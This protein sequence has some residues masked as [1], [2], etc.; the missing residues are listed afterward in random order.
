M[1]KTYYY[2][3]RRSRLHSLRAS[4]EEAVRAAEEAKSHFETGRCSEGNGFSARH[5]N[6]EYGY[7]VLRAIPRL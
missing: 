4:K 2:R 5:L 3:Y 1:R 7:Y 6:R